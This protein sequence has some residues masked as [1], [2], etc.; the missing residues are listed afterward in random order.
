MLPLK[1]LI[2][3]SLAHCS[4]SWPDLVWPYVC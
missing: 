2:S 3:R 1:L 4:K